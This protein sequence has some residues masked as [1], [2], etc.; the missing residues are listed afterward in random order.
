[1]PYVRYR[2]T[3]IKLDEDP[4]SGI[5][6][7]GHTPNK[8]DLHHWRNAYPTRKVKKNP[9]LALENTGEFGY[10]HHKMANAIRT[11]IEIP[12]EDLPKYIATMDE[13]TIKNFRIQL[14]RSLEIIGVDNV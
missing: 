2:Q 3:K 5:C 10:P 4:R 9:K 13:V 8:T 1:M 6:A 14:L 12:E 7:I 11:F